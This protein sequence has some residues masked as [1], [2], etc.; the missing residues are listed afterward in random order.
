MRKLLIKVDRLHKHAKQKLLIAK[1]NIK[2][3]QQRIHSTDTLVVKIK[4][5]F[6]DEQLKL[7]SSE[8]I[9]VPLWSNNTILF[10]ISCVAAPVGRQP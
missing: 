10:R 7:L 4:K 6:N 8:F 9:K 1:H 5:I 2:R 3:L